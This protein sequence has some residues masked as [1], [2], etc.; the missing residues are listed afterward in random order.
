MNGKFSNSN[1]QKNFIPNSHLINLVW[2]H[3]IPLKIKMLKGKLNLMI[4]IYIYLTNLINCI[5]ASKY[6]INIKDAYGSM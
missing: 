1:F 4:H 3:A 6:D 5:F 2:S